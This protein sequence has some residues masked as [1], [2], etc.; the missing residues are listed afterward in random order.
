MHVRLRNHR[1]R[2][3]RAV[4]LAAPLLVVAVLWLA[5]E[6][7]HP[8]DQA[9]RQI[10]TPPPDHACRFWG[11]V[12]SGPL[13][14]LVID[15]LVTGTYSLKS[16]ASSN[17][18]GWAVGFEAPVLT[19][20][21]LQAPVVLRGGP[22]ADHAFDDRYDQAVGQMF[23]LE[24]TRAV[25]H[26]RAASSG[27]AD[28][29]DPHPFQR[30]DLLFAH[31]G[32]LRT[33]DLLDLILEDDPAYLDEHPADFSDPYIDSELYF[34]YLRKVIEGSNS[35]GGSRSGGHPRSGLPRWPPQRP[36]SIEGALKEALLTLYDRGAMGTAANC[37]LASP[38][39]LFAV[40]F[41]PGDHDR[42]RVRYRKVG[43]S[44]IV[45][46]EP[47]GTDTTGWV[48]LPPKSLGVFTATGAP[49]IVSLYP[50][51]G[52]WLAVK[53]VDYD[54][55]LIPPSMG[56]GNHRI[57]LGERIEYRPM[58]VNDGTQAAS[59]VTA[60]LG[61]TDSLIEMV[62]EAVTYPDL[63]PAGTALPEA[64]FV[65]DV[66][67]G[68]APSHS[69]DFTLE[70]TAQNP[71]GETITWTRTLSE[72][73]EGPELHYANHLVDD[74]G[75]GILEPGE[76]AQIW[77]WVSNEGNADATGLTAH[78]A[79]DSP[80][81]VID[82]PTAELDT[83][84]MRETGRLSPAFV[85]T[86]A[87]DCPSPEMI[88]FEVSLEA[89]WAYATLFEL[90]L[91]VGGFVDHLENGDAN[92]THAPVQNGYG[93]AWHLSDARNHTPAGVF[94][95]KCGSP[96]SG[97]AYPAMLDAV[98]VTPEIELGDVCEL[99]FWHHM[100]AQLSLSAPGYAND[101]GLVEAS[102]NGAPWQQL[103]PLTGYDYL[104]EAA[105]PPGPFPQDTPVF[106]GYYGWRQAVCRIEGYSGTIQFRFRFGSDGTTGL[107]GEA[108]GWHIDDVEVFSYTALA[109]AD[110]ADPKPLRAS[111]HIGG[112][113]PFR[114][115][116][117]LIFEVA[118]PGPVTL[119]ILDLEGRLVRHLIEGNVNPGRHRIVWDGTDA[120]G[121]PVPSGLYFYRLRSRPERFEEVRRIIRLR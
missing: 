29:P 35:G 93:D 69:W 61:T 21:G 105:T 67:P 22:S 113:S 50:P 45:A 118:R 5:F 62:S 48:S 47:V 66:H 46:S 23:A 84:R 14:S 7:T 53:K 76:S 72:R 31:N 6:G 119:S 110:P 26:I 102:I 94:S 32:T 16:L 24:P 9:L 56:N 87:P 44:W 59:Q 54:D 91:P 121:R 36:R 60:T 13:D 96:D 27:H 95:F 104:I 106:S 28:V 1:A 73:A 65:F 111:L 64:P 99:R 17:P 97:A 51:E 103:Y 101:G 107:M 18:D 109:A 77:V 11:L 71:A 75:D 41:D 15:Q 115:E 2:S 40:R 117:T 33:E 88:P 68:G 98:L 116:T 74:G 89:D 37:L 100:R 86:V 3:R 90:A 85:I 57:E 4:L 58:L 25:V 39:T 82:Q 108:E 42:Y 30:D 120:A 55:D 78:L 10:P 63:A 12:G 8:P 19:G 52:P 112:P 70:I 43:G 83:L 114:Q 92:W 81:V 49:E 79:T 80:H 20:A 34:L 38:D